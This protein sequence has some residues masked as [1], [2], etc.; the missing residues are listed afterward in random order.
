MNFVTYLALAAGVLIVVNV[1][2]VALVAIVNRSP[3]D[4]DERPNR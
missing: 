2:F 3:D 4:A 1:L